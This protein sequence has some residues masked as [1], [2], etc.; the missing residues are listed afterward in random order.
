LDDVRAVST[1]GATFQPLHE[2]PE[3]AAV[4]RQKDAVSPH[5]QQGEAARQIRE[6]IAESKGRPTHEVFRVQ[7]DASKEAWR[8][9]FFSIVNRYVPSRLPDDATPELRL[10]CEDAFLAL[11]ERMVD[12]ERSF[13]GG[14]GLFPPPLK[15]AMV[16]PKT[17]SAPPTVKWRGGMLHV[18]LQLNRG[19][20]TPFVA[21]PENT[22]KS[23]GL[24]ISSPEKVMLN[25]PVETHI[26]FE[27][28]TLKVEGVGRVVGV[29][30]SYPLGFSVKLNDLDEEARSMIRT[31]VQRG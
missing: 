31:W 4:L 2:V 26:G 13:R 6:W 30:T 14:S 16:V 29:K 11:A 12:I 7:M 22:W 17:P 10:A 5:R 23:D 20:I 8:A 15:P 18:A 19:D 1:D 21:D 25:T 3:L 27:G 28:H 9:S 24:F